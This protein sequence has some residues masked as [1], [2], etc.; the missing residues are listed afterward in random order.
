MM[1]VPP[2]HAEA[3]RH[4][5]AASAL[6]PDSANGLYLVAKEYAQLGA[7]D[8]A[9]TAYRKV[10]AMCPLITGLAHLWMGEALSKKKDWEAA[11]AEIREAIRLLPE[12][13]APMSVLSS[14]YGA[15]GMAL[16]GAGRP[17]EALQ[18]MLTQLRDGPAWAQDPRYYIRYNAGCCAMN[19]AD[20][21]GMNALA[22][23]ERSAYRKQALELLTADLAAI[24]K[25]AATDG[26]F[27]HRTMQWWL[28][29]ADLASVREPAAVDGL[30]QDEREAW[31]KLWADVHEL[32]DRS[33]PQADP[34]SMS[35]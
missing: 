15:L 13:R 17:A 25:L 9:I 14:G 34:R 28:G 5:S 12:Q 18:V 1:V 31:R 16:A 24:R 23:V 19:C 3:L 2:D 30:P 22:P 20:V 10:I 11:I 26:A 4:L 27:V 33:T 32:R 35:R 29:D 7:Y 6:R 8:Q 21:K